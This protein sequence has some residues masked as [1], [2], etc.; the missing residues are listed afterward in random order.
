MNAL[1]YIAATVEPGSDPDIE[2][3]CTKFGLTSR[4]WGL[5]GSLLMANAP[6]PAA[7]RVLPERSREAPLSLVFYPGDLRDH[8]M[9]KIYGSP[10]RLTCRTPSEVLVALRTATRVLKEARAMD[11][12]QGADHLKT[13]THDTRGLKFYLEAERRVTATVEPAHN[14][15]ADVVKAYQRAGLIP[16]KPTSDFDGRTQYVGTRLVDSTDYYGVIIT[17]RPNAPLSLSIEVGRQG[18]DSLGADFAT[19]ALPGIKAL[20]AALQANDVTRVDAVLRTLEFPA[21]QRKEIVTKFKRWPG[22]SAAIRR[23]FQ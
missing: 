1:Q 14:E 12:D 15:D 21:S 13:I 2:K 19:K 23:A 3:V 16:A 20:L 7:V 18:R 8:N 22:L 11:S 10:T 5:R 17:V 6:M 9:I 4:R